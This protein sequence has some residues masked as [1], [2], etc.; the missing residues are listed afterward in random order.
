MRATGGA[1]G[2]NGRVFLSAE[3][4]D[5]GFNASWASPAAKVTTLLP[6]FAQSRDLLPNEPSVLIEAT[7]LLLPRGP[8]P[9]GN[10]P[11]TFHPA[12]ALAASGLVLSLSADGGVSSAVPNSNGSVIFNST[13]PPTRGRVLQWRV[14]PADGAVDAGARAI[15]IRAVPLN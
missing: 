14:R 8:L 6:A 3:N 15:A 12:E 4:F 5:A 11:A 7:A 10:S 1:G 9:S 13:L 2:G